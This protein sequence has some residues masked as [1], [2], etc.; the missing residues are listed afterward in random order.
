MPDRRW[1]PVFSTVGAALLLSS[2][3]ADVPAENDPADDVA[4]AEEPASSSSETAE[5]AADTSDEDAPA[6]S[7]AA[8]PGTADAAEGDAEHDAEQHPGGRQLIGGPDGVEFF[9]ISPEE[10]DGS[11][12]F[13]LHCNDDEALAAKAAHND[14]AQPAGW[15]QDW[16]GSG[17]MPD[18]L[19]HPDYLQ[20]DEWEH[21]ESHFA[22]WEG[23]ETSTLVRGGQ[24][25]EEVDQNLWQQSQARADWEPN[26]P[27]G[28]CAEQWAQHDG[29]DPEDYADRGNA[30]DG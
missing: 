16:D 1:I 3:A 24:S 30:N 11:E 7:D 8:G 26:P 23:I 15:P 13:H 29:G 2:C 21:L 5:L 20:I 22:C 17:A 14:G 25:Q 19:C 10:D 6:E 9:Y 27:G 4:A 12:V 28:T 18:P